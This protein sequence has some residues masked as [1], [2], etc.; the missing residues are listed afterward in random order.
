MAPDRLRFDFVHFTPLTREQIARDRA[1]RQRADP[2][3]HAGADRGEEH[4]GSDRRR[5]DGALRREVRRHVRVVS[6]PASASSCAAARTAAPPATSAVRHRLGGRRR[7][8]RAAH[9]G[10]HRTGFAGGVS[11]RSRRNRAGSSAALNARPGE[12]WRELAALQEE[13]RKLARELQQAKMKAAMGG[14]HRQSTGTAK[15]A[16]QKR[17]DRTAGWA[18]AAAEEPI[19]PKQ[20]GRIRRK[21]R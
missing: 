10:D 7:R 16:P 13:N 19:L 6:I 9:R 11:A 1:H 18:A 21:F 4:A 15:K 20:A 17:T 2:A 5:R 12:L 8:R 3:Q 14:G